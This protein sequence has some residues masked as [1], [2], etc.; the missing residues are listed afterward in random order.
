MKGSEL[1]SELAEASGLPTDLIGQ[2]L[3]HLVRQ[4]G[5]DTTEV[6]LD[7]LR[8]LLANYLQ[9]VLIEAKSSLEND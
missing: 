7:D 2:E 3:S 5:K 1:I 9:E 8:E 4:A 6:T